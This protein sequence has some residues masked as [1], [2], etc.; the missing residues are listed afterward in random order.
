MSTHEDFKRHAE[1]KGSSDRAFGIVFAI[2]F[3]LV[4]LAPLRMHHPIR[5]WA[6]GAGAVV[7]AATLIRPRWLHPFN[8]VWTKLGLL[9]GRIV[10]PVVMGLM[11]FLVVTPT[12]FLFRLFGKD[13]LRLAK[14]AGAR[15]YWI[16][17]RPP[18]PAPESMA[19][20]F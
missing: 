11:F 5:W 10:S 14:D 20:Q 18:G 7:L 15:T 13:P 9:L 4:A 16:E 1:A 17:R 3:S 19:N 12:A 8:Y 6:L 2:F